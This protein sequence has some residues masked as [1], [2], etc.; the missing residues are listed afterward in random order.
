MNFNLYIFGN[1]RGK[2][3]QYP[4]DYTQKMF[5]EACHDVSGARGVIYRSHDL[6]HYIFIEDLGNGRFIGICLIFNHIRFAYPKKLFGFMRS[7]IENT[8]IRGRYYLERTE[9]GDIAFTVA[10][11]CDDIKAYE[12]LK[13]VINA[14]LDY[15]NDFGAEELG[16]KYEGVHRTK[17]V[18]GSEDDSVIVKLSDESN[19][20]VVEYE[21]GI[22][23]NYTERIIAG[24]RS[25][26]ADRDSVISELNGRISELER[27]KK[28]YHKVV[29]L[30]ILVLGCCVGLYFLYDSLTETEG[31][32]RD[33]RNDLMAAQRTVSSQND[34]IDSLGRR[35]DSLNLALQRETQLKK[36]AED[37]VDRVKSL[38]PVSVTSGHYN[39]GAREY[40]FN[41]HS[42]ETGSES[43]TLKII[44]EANGQI[45]YENF[46]PSLNEG[47]GSYT[48]Y[49]SRYLDGSHWHTFEVWYNGNIIGGS[50]H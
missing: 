5:A 32:L 6:V 34:T 15:N 30:F 35:N 21:S 25:K 10:E 14:A 18:A 45:Y 42:F 13:S 20:V 3:S 31:S 7:L 29:L 44:N 47:T 50:R 26:I 11:F 33:T 9:N 17:Y 37:V 2:Y 41:Y 16:K 39:Y 38:V 12:Y 36:E 43:M 49:V 19:R 22:D 4:Q 8:A 23:S 24:L 27:K 28:Q 48:V 1:P 46:T 40:R